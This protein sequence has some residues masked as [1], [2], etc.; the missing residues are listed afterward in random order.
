MNREIVRFVQKRLNEEGFSLV[1]DGIA[2]PKTMGALRSLTEI[3][4]HWT[5]RECLSG[6]L[7]LLMGRIFGP[8]IING[9][10]T[11]ETDA[12]YRKLRFHFSSREG[13]VY[14]QMNWPSQ[15]EKELFK[16]YGK[17]GQN[18]VRLH[19]PYPHILSWKP[20]KVI[21]SF[22]CHEKVHDSL[23]RVLHRVFEHYGYDRIQELNLDK[24]GG[25]LD[26]RKIRKG[27][28]YSTHSWGI[29]VDYDPARN[30]QTWGRDKA[31]FAQ[32]EYDKW[33][34][35]WIDEGWNS[36]GLKKNYD[37]MH[38]QAAVI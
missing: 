2:G 29:A 17:V 37:W 24:W 28:R 22:F 30:Q 4:N 20:E 33:W 32:P 27:T 5:R 19:L 23:E 9:R 31:I 15:S 11:D 36:L 13:T 21:N 25:C 34:E 26:V 12:M 6:Y 1:C 35:I 3:E 8:V 10:W 16:F 7:Q 38:I 14:Q 18:Q